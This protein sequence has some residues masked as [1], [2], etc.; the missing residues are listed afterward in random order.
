[1][2]DVLRWVDFHQC[3]RT[4]NISEDSGGW[5]SGGPDHD[6]YYSDDDDDDGRLLCTFSICIA[7][8][9]NALYSALYNALYL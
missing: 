7:F 5:T 3:L 4:S 1:M 6:Y 9:Y 2:A 8:L